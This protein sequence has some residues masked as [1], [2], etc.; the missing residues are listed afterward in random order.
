MKN[1]YNFSNGVRGKFYNENA[2]INI[3]IYLDK[4]VAEFIEEVSRRNK[5]DPQTIVNKVLR[6]NK[7]M[8]QTW[9]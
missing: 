7:N 2:K 5:I 3:P 1:E 4:D 6:K 8:I 9:Q